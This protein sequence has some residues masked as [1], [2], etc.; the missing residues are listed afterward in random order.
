LKSAETTTGLFFARK[1]TRLVAGIASAGV[2]AGIFVVA[3]APAM[4]ATDADCAPANTVDTALFGTAADIQNL[5]DNPGV[6]VVCLSGTFVVPSTLTYDRDVTIYGLSAAVLDGADA[7]GILEDIGAGSALTVENL[8]MT[9]GN[10]TAG[11]AIRALSNLSTV[12]V[13]NSTFDNNT[14]DNA[15][16]IA[17]YSVFISNSTF[18]NNSAVG[19]PA[20]AGAILTFS[21]VIALSTFVDNST[22]SGNGS[23][24]YYED[25]APLQLVGNIFAST[26]AVAHVSPFNGASDEGGNIFSTD[27]VNEGVTGPQP[28]S[29]FGVSSALL[30]NGAVL[31]NNGGRTPTVALYAGSPAVNFVPAGL[32][33]SVIA[34]QR[35]VARDARSDSGAYE[36]VP[37]ASI[38][39]TGIA[40]TG[41]LG[42]VA[43]LLLAIGGLAL[44]VV[45]RSRP[46]QR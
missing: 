42:G 38:P 10:G 1:G 25:L 17:G 4:A 30:F 34:D 5:L 12:V 20:L 2:V 46:L 19:D 39:P 32:L 40:A 45:R 24:I 16:A 33:P 7:V 14:A 31:A 23:S 9:R 15:G 26:V 22:P 13:R 37:A 35:G 3:A 27:S 43:A 6:P 21:G 29:A 41:V 44:G 18:V 8:R 28:T 36:Y 11:G